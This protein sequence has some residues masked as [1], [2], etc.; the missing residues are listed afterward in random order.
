M[1]TSDQGLPVRSGFNPWLTARDIFDQK[2]PGVP[3]SDT[4]A[5]RMIDEVRKIGPRHLWR[6][7][8]GTAEA[9]IEV[10]YTCLPVEAIV[11]Y[12]AR[13]KPAVAAVQANDRRC[14]R[15]GKG[16]LSMA[17]GGRVRAYIV[18]LMIAQPR[19]AASG[20]RDRCIEEFGFDVIIIPQG[21][22]TLV[23][24]P[25]MRT[26]QAFVKMLRDTGAA[27]VQS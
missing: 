16:V 17:E 27:N 19:L 13:H 25:P 26:F 7:S 24:M 5:A 4:H 18:K 6:A 8:A 2:L 12:E 21:L 10:H 20:I 14:A 9:G 1:R 22:P 15:L 11:A 3:R 23:P